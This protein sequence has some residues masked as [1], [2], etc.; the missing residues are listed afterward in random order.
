MLP[1]PSSSAPP[2]PPACSPQDMSLV[3]LLLA[4]LWDHGVGPCWALPAKHDHCGGSSPSPPCSAHRAQQP[5]PPRCHRPCCA[6]KA[7][8]PLQLC[9]LFVLQYGKH[10]AMSYSSSETGWL[11]VACIKQ[12][13]FTRSCPQ[14]VSSLNCKESNFFLG[15]AGIWWRLK[16]HSGWAAEQVFPSFASWVANSFRAKYDFSFKIWRIIIISLKPGVSE[17]VKTITAFQ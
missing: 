3:R 13:K 9:L 17:Y 15:T 11:Q 2:T 4:S 8:A 12:R 10:L 14:M 5:Q 1:H 6:G 16:L 7:I